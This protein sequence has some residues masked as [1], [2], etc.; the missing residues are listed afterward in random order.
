MTNNETILDLIMRDMVC[1]STLEH[2]D[3]QIKTLDDRRLQTVRARIALAEKI[4][5]MIWP[6]GPTQEDD[7]SYRTFLL[8]TGKIAIVTNKGDV[9][10]QDVTKL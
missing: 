10:A 6:N 5:P 4:V 2:I 9:S 1:A 7:F 8:P 3:E